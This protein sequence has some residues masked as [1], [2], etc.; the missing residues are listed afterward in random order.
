M[1]SILF[2]AIDS[3][4][5]PGAQVLVAR[6]D[7][8]LFEKA[9]GHHTYD[10][11]Q[12]VDLD[13]MYDLASV[14]KVTSGLPLLMNLYGQGKLGLDI[15][16]GNY[17]PELK[18]SNKATLTFREI[19][20]HQAGLIPYI[21]FWQEAKKSNGKYKR[22]TFKTKAKRRFPIE[23]TNQLF[24]HKK[25]NSKMRQ[26]IAKSRLNGNREYV[27]S[28]LIFQLLPKMIENISGMSFEKSLHT[29]IFEPIGAT[30]ICYNPLEKYPKEKIVPTENDTLF[31]NQLIH[32]TVHDEAAAMWRGISCNAGLFSNA[33]S[34]SKLFQLY[35]NNG[36]LEEKSIIDSSAIAEF[37]RC[38]YC[39]SGNRRGLGF[40]KPIIEYDANVAYVAKSA[41]P[42]SFGHSGFTGTFVWADPEHD[43]IFIFLSNRVYPS[44]DHR[45]LY[46]M[47]V[48]PRM[49]Q[50]VYDYFVN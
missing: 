27:Y 32:G 18:N 8:I 33:R 12:K 43:L 39:E 1:D 17:I 50:L 7:R 19:L 40:D 6:H 24:L 41:S 20:S 21:V 26:R 4:A 9:Y 13:H 23:I 44:R 14:T 5:F 28:G 38:Q 15:P 16:V 49:H 42:S 31:R 3:Q 48:R 22:K 10:Q 45:Q 37:T 35:L 2:E 47:N 46:S 25:Y 30:D 36:Y 34:L 29:E 11:K